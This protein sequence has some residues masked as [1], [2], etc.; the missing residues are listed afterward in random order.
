[1]KD[2]VAQRD[3]KLCD[4]LRA[5]GL[6][7]SPEIDLVMTTKG[8]QAFEKFVRSGAIWIRDAAGKEWRWMAGQEWLKLRRFQD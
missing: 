6:V 8:V 5:N 7:I 2:Y 4:T 3:Q 1:M